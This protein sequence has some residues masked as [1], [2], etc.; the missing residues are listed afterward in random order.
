MQE[1]RFAL[2]TFNAQRSTVASRLK[3]PPV[4]HIHYL[5]DKW[6]TAA[7]RAV[8]GSI[9]KGRWWKSRFPSIRRSMKICRGLQWHNPWLCPPGLAHC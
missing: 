5:Y 7:P 8:R 9:R 3:L 1:K 2:I 6:S 4:L